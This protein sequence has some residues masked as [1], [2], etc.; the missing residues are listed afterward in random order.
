MSV[1]N[2]VCFLLALVVVGCYGG[3]EDSFE[4]GLKASTPDRDQFQY[5]VLGEDDLT[6]GC[7][8][9]VDPEGKSHSTFY[10]SGPR[11]GYRLLKQDGKAL[12]NPDLE[13][14]WENFPKECNERIE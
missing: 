6:Y 11:I 7:Y 5:K 4:Y 13:A 12:D 14:K 3:N 10:T 8:G 1:L 2:T 9:Y